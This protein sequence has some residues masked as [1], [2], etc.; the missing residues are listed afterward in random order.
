[1]ARRL[2]LTDQIGAVYFNWRL[3]APMV[4]HDL[5]QG[6]GRHA[7]RESLREDCIGQWKWGI[8]SS[9]NRNRGKATEAKN[10]HLSA[11]E[12]KKTIGWRQKPIG[13]TF[14]GNLSATESNT[15]VTASGEAGGLQLEKIATTAAKETIGWACLDRAPEKSRDWRRLV[16]VARLRCGA[17]RRK[18]PKTRLCSWR[19]K[20]SG[21]TC[22]SKAKQPTIV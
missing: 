19:K 4:C 6:G 17:H 9:T 7:S 22:L 2:T 13:R 1:M 18:G 20:S 14:P 10:L 12:S 21:G 3:S 5:R 8:N 15:A 16:S 11:G